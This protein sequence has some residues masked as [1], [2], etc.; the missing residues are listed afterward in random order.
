MALLSPV[1]YLAHMSTPIGIICAK[2]FV[3]E[4]ISCHNT[5]ININ[6]NIFF[7]LWALHKVYIY[8]NLNL[9]WSIFPFCNLSRSLRSGFAWL[10]LTQKR[11]WFKFEKMH[12]SKKNSKHFVVPI[13]LFFS[14][15]GDCNN[16]FESILSWTIELLWPYAIL[17]R[18]IA[19]ISHTLFNFEVLDKLI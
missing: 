13:L 2:A 15:Q 16:P 9:Y 12:C 6:V 7:Y 11:M 19:G 3:G 1:A 10:S 5:N 4:V 14:V 18:Y 8:I 17:H